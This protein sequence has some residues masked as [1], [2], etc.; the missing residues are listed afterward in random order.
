MAVRCM[1]HHRAGC[2]PSLGRAGTDHAARA[3][4]AVFGLRTPARPPARGDRGGA[5]RFRRRIRRCPPWRRRMSRSPDSRRAVSGQEIRCAGRQR[6]GKTQAPLPTIPLDVHSTHPTAGARRSQETGIVLHFVPASRSPVRERRARVMVE[7]NARLTQHA[8]ERPV[9][10]GTPDGR[11][12]RYRT[13]STRPSR[14]RRA[15]RLSSGNNG[16]VHASSACGRFG[17]R[18]SRPASSCPAASKRILGAD[19]FRHTLHEPNLRAARWH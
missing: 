11:D 6:V 17:S 18:P 4:A 1:N 19:R 14:K 16:S 9:P 2:R 5:S 7:T 15:S 12:C 13:S 8:G 10:R 3:R